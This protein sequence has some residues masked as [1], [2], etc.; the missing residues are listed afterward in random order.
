MM[1]SDEQVKAAS[2]EYAQAY[3][4][5]EK[6][7]T[8]QLEE[9]GFQPGEFEDWSINSDGSLNIEVKDVQIAKHPDETDGT[10]WEVWVS[11]EP[12]IPDSQVF[13]VEENEDGSLFVQWHG[14]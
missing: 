5:R 9:Q 11:L 14:N 12:E 3:F 6:V 7:Y 8:W 4:T 13:L 1:V 2:R 10:T